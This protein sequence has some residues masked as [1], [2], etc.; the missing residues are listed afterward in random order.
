V[1]VRK[2]TGEGKSTQHSVTEKL[3]VVARD[4]VTK[5]VTLSFQLGAYNGTEFNLTLTE[6]EKDEL[7]SQLDNK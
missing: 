2:R 6:T 7:V 1:E 5:G 3:R 4:T